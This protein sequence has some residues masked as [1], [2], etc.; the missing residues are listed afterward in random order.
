MSFRSVVKSNVPKVDLASIVSLVVGPFKSGKTRLWKEVTELHYPN[1]PNAALLIAWEQGFETW[2]LKNF[3]SMTEY[4]STEADR[5]EF[6]RKEVV[7]GLIEEAKTGRISKLIGIDTADKCVD[8]ATAWIIQRANKKYGKQFAGLQEISDS[9]S[10]N[11]W[12]M[13]Y[14]ELSTQFDKLRNAG[15][16]LMHLA[17]T[18]EKETTLHD[19]RKYNSLELMMHNT[20]K[21]VFESQARF[22]CCLHSEVTIL[23]KDGNILDENI[24]NKKGKEIG[25]RF[26]ETQV[27]MYFRP[28]Q[29]IS[30]AGGSFINLPEKMEY[31]AENYLQVY[32]EAVKGQLDNPEKIEE[33]K[34]EQAIEREAKS[35]KFV[36]Q[37]AAKANVK[38]PSEIIAE[39]TAVIDSITEKD[40]RKKAASTI[41]K[42]L[43][44][45]LAAEYR[46]STDSVK[47]QECLEAIRSL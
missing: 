15:Y 27:Y 22:I 11:G 30:I 29:Y 26:H 1:D 46:T 35:Q 36:E 32:E 6:F 44:V 18:K 16:G 5:W 39:I 23:D 13:L 33:I 14:D 9:T 2:H 37:E 3:I 17:W 12:V 20:A 4:A 19:G 45:K 42:I 28:S 7:P 40:E 8:A 34:A 10:E 31:S 47:L 21:K 43:G 38:D 25:T 24:K 41:A